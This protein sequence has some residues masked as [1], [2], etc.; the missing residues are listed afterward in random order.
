MTPEKWQLLERA[1]VI[2]ILALLLVTVMRGDWIPRPFF[3]AAT[4]EYQRQ[5]E[6]LHQDVDECRQVR[7]IDK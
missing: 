7:A 3:D 5:I 1:G 2:G 6:D 4:Q